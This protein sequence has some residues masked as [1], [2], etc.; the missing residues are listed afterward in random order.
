MQD[1]AEVWPRHLSVL[2]PDDSR[3]KTSYWYS[4]A[5]IVLKIPIVPLLVVTGLFHVSVDAMLMLKKFAQSI[6]FIVLIF[7]F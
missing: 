4:F 7:S 6:S 5:R 2:E 1:D 3:I